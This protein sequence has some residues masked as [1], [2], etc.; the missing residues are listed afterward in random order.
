MFSF[1]KRKF[2]SQYLYKLPCGKY[3]DPLNVYRKLITS[4]IN[5]LLDKRES[6]VLQTYVK[7]ETD[8]CKLIRDTFEIPSLDKSGDGY[9][10]KDCLELLDNYFEYIEKKGEKVKPSVTSPQITESKTEDLP[11]NNDCGCS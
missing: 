10:D 4:N 3:V 6:E 7:A 11:K 9:T 8:L 5:D 1:F 2:K